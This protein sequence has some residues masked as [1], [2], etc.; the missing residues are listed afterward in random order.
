M[1]I[2]AQPFDLR[3]CVESALDLVTTRA[4]EKHLDIAYVFEGDVPAGDR[5]R[6][7]AAAPDHAQPALQRGE[8]HRARRG[9]ADGDA[10]RRAP[11][12]EVELTFAVR[13]TGIG[14]S[15]EGMG[16]LFQ[17]FSQ[18]D[19]STTRKYGGTGL[20]LAISKRLA[21]LMG[22]RMWA[23]SDGPGKGSTFSF[24]IDAPIARAAARAARA[25]SS[26][27]SRSS[28][29]SACSSS[30][31]TPPTGACSSCRPPSGAWQSRATESPHEALRWLDAGEAFDLA[32]LD[33]HM[34]EMDG[35]ALARQI[36]ERR[37]DA[38]AGAVQLAR[39]ARGRRRRRA[40]RRLPREADPPVAAVRHAGRTA[41][42]RDARPRPPPRRPRPRL[43]P[44]MAA[45]HPLRILLAEDNVVN[46]KLALRILQQMGY[47]ADLASNG[48]EA[49]ESV[50]APGLRRGA[51]GRA[52]AGDG[53]ARGHAPDHA[54][55]WPPDERPRIVAMTANAMQGD[56]E[57]C[58]AAGMDDYLTKPIRVDRLVEALNQ[59]SARE[60]R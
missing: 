26:A 44:G 18:A 31:T 45:R 38:A 48:I 53:R 56:R 55:S 37:A 52:D 59:V 24:T 22:G 35:V 8:V 15:A 3:E 2:E 47:R 23:E 19:S 60:D 4:V 30:T 28:R 27:R 11:D 49:V 58:L 57:M 25:T 42:A 36:R 54:R 14:L 40:L 39:P 46:Q 1:D 41:G 34:P 50:R 12:G 21:E 20:G 33:M 13:D 43:D 51:D 29:A 5:R 10:R 17:S 16:R 32:I 6:R 9:R 7:D